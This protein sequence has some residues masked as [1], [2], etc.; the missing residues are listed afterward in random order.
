MHGDDPTPGRDARAGPSELS[1]QGARQEIGW[2]R[3]RIDIGTLRACEVGQPAIS[4]F[5]AGDTRRRQAL[6]VARATGTAR[7]PDGRD[8]ID[9]HVI[10]MPIEFSEQIGATANHRVTAVPPPG[11][12]DTREK[13]RGPGLFP[14]LGTPGGFSRL[15]SQPQSASNRWGATSGA[16]LR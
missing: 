1:P 16:H 9:M 6:E 7:V 8:R 13:L 4:V 12:P 3:V 15:I 2:G 10:R 11:W 14:P 5:V